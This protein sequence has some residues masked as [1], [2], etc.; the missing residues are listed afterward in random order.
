MQKAFDKMHLLMA[1]DALAVYPDHNKRLDIYTD[2]S[3]FQLGAFIIQ[4]G[5][6][7]AYFLQKLTKSQQ[8]YTTME[9]DMLSIVATLK[10][11][12]GMLL[13]VDIHIFTDHINLMFDTIKMQRV[14]RWHT[15]IEEFSP[16]LNYIEGPR[17]ILAD[18]LSRLCCLVTPAQIAEG[19]K[20]VDPAE[21]LMRKK[22]KCIS[23]IKNTLVFTM[24]MTY[25][26]LHIQMRI[27]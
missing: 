17:N 15:K 2:A 19:K 18:T 6:L 16:I 21:V 26:T 5:R 23:W 14:L 8:N 22:T 3:D 20:L 7:F 13:G 10:E 4:E 1:A 25:L 12:Q 24:R 11:F 9:K 27:C